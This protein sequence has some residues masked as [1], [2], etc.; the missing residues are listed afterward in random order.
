[1]IEIKNPLDLPLGKYIEQ[2]E[3]RALEAE[4]KV[5]LVDDYFKGQISLFPYLVIDAFR[6]G[7]KV[8]RLFRVLGQAK[9]KEKKLLKQIDSLIY[10]N[11]KL[12]AGLKGRKKNN[13]IKGLFVALVG[14]E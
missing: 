4:G 2:L 8:K 11:K 1:M 14:R 5:L 6:K 3:L 10:E 13:I 9:R 7:K 12:R